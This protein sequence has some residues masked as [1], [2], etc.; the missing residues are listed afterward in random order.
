MLYHHVPPFSIHQSPR[1]RITL[2]AH[3]PRLL[4]HAFFATDMIY[5]IVEGRRPA[6]DS[7]KKIE[8]FGVSNDR[9][10]TMLT[11]NRPV[12]DFS[13]VPS[14]RK[15]MLPYIFLVILF[16]L[17]V[18]TGQ[19]FQPVR[20]NCGGLQYKDPATNI[21]WLADSSLYNVGNKGRFVR[22][23]SNSSVVIANTTA[24]LREIYCSHQ[25]FR[26]LVGA[27][28]DAQPYEYSIPVLNTTS[29]YTVRLHFA[30]IVRA[31]FESLPK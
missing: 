30:E 16:P 28:R 23:C 20:I 31:Y 8:A 5:E 2:H 13:R 27:T 17:A 6:V 29:S 1:L 22:K 3:E 25:L 10:P 15:I 9:R 26:A 7:L 21:T 19:T 14:F 18:V 12:S 24:T 11:I 4:M